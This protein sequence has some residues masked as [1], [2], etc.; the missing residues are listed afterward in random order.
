[1]RDNEPWSERRVGFATLAVRS[2]L[3]PCASVRLGPS[4]FHFEGLRSL[5]SRAVPPPQSSFALSSCPK[6]FGSGLAYQGFGPPRGITVSRP[7]PQRHPR[8]L[9]CS[10]LRLS[11]PLD[12]FLRETSHRLVSS[13]SHV[14]GSHSFRGFSPRAAFLPSSGRAAP[15]SFVAPSSP[16]EN[17]LPVRRA[18]TPR[19]FSTRGSVVSR[20]GFTRPAARSPL[21]VS[22]SS[23]RSVS[24][25]PSGSPVGSAHDVLPARSSV[26]RWSR[27]TVFSVSRRRP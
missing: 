20:F 7:L 10:V 22:V 3:F 4:T 17:R 14:Q 8:P 5:I 16:A 18:P 19:L 21:R 13:G 6:P 27:P 12:G 25:L 24:A 11:Q 9:L 1:V 15:L 2:R 23:G 26:A